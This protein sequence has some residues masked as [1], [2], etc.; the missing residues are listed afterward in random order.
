M[1]HIGTTVGL[2]RMG[3]KLN[4]AQKKAMEAQEKTKAKKNS[5]DRVSIIR[6]ELLR[7]FKDSVKLYKK[8]YNGD[9]YEDDAQLFDR[10]MTNYIGMT[11]DD[12]I[13]KGQSVSGEVKQLE[14]GGDSNVKIVLRWNADTGFARW[15]L[16]PSYN[17]FDTYDDVLDEA[18]KEIKR[19]TFFNDDEGLTLK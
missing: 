2:G 7:V 16:E 9:S 10:K 15:R 14:V 4:P 19:S 6:S 1:S 11:V 18:E 8:K 12:D 13:L 5:S 3:F 17:K